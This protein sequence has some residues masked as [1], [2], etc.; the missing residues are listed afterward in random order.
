MR[1]TPLAAILEGLEAAPA[2]ERTLGIYLSVPFCRTKCH[3]CDWV[4]EIPVQRLRFN[5]AERSPY[6]EAVCEQIRHAGPLTREFGYAPHVMYWGGGTPTRFETEELLAI[7]DALDSSFDLSRL[8]QWSMETTPDCLTEEKIDALR[9]KGLGR[10]SVGVQ[11]FNDDH[12]RMSGRGHDVAMARKAIELIKRMD[13]PCFNI[14]LISGLPG[15][16]DESWLHTIRTTLELEPSHISIYP[17]RPAEDTTMAR[18]IAT[19]HHSTLDTGRMIA[20]YEI[21]MDLLTE[22]SYSEYIHGYWI[23]REDDRDMDA[24]YGYNLHGD[25]LGLGAGADSVLARHL[26]VNER[27]AYDAFLKD[28][29][30]FGLAIKFSLADPGVL[31][32]QLGGALMTAG[33]INFRRFEALT[34]LSFDEFRNTP[35]MAR[36]FDHLRRLGAEFVETEESVALDPAMIHKVY[37]RYVTAA[38]TLRPLWKQ[39]DL[40]VQ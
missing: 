4:T 24:V 35:F 12:L 21:A 13:F 28:P 26:L 36:W 27:T 15:E 25:K 10:L 33:G 40:L 39:R 6:V 29:T 1:R 37:I 8:T 19:G 38:Q 11:S 9:K 3:F 23:R 31:A 14:D 20:V 32:N 34:G 22:A 17:Y 30:G 5:R 2:L 7:W 18:Q 16:S